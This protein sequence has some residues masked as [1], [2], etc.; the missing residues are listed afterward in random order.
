MSFL[1]ITLIASCCAFVIGW[2]ITAG[3][4][5]YA[6]A[7]QLLDHPN[8]RSSHTVPTP[9][10]GGLSIVIA[11][12]VGVLILWFIRAIDMH[13]ALAVVGGGVAI[14][15][16]GFMDDRDSLPVSVRMVV[17]IVAAVGAMYVL[18]GLSVMQIGGRLV[19]LGIYGDILGTLAIIWTLNLFNFMDGIDGIATSEAIF[20]T[21]AGAGLAYFMGASGSTSLVAVLLAA[22]CLGFLTWNWP[23]AKIF[24]GDVG[25]GYLGYVIAVLA[26]AAARE[27]PV[28]LFVWLILGGVFFVD[29]TMTLIR[30]LIRHE[31]VYVA[32]R[33]HAYQWLSRR[34]NS[35]K[36]VTVLVLCF[37]V[38]WL[39]PLAWFCLYY[40]NNAWWI[41]GLALTPVAALAFIAGAGRPE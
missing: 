8:V 36:R 30:R 24:M 2:A 14:A 40:P 4:R 27:N 23:P 33:S 41:S 5:R 6:L 13:L 3:V 35:H 28:A 26:I 22:S 7:T 37:N 19:D 25:S 15:A 39:L 11:C 31:R 20:V 9:R 32:H 17:H 16:V 10:G 34:W 29:A 38:L 12:T 21:G 18:G 1:I